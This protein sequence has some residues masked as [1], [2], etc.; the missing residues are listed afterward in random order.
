MLHGPNLRLFKQHLK[1]G[2]ELHQATKAILQQ[3]RLRA[4]VKRKQLPSAVP[5]NCKHN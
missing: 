3:C 4:L 2:P 5:V 1:H